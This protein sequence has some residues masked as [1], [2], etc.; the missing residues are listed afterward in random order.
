MAERSRKI[1]WGII[2]ASFH[3]TL[4]QVILFPSCV[5]FALM[6][7]GILR[8]ER[9]GDFFRMKPEWMVWYRRAAAALVLVSGFFGFMG[10]FYPKPDG[11]IWALLP[12]ILEYIV[13]Y[14]LM[15]AYTAEK[16][17]YRGLRRGYVFVMGAALTGYGVS[18]MLHAQVWQLHACVIMLVCR[19]M[20]LVAVFSDKKELNTESR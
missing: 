17:G 3:I 2:L 1:F 13:F 11:T 18:L 6:Y 14:F 16:P 10:I 12:C 5:G 20:L 7:L 19:L 9:Q 15:E 4:F 8:L